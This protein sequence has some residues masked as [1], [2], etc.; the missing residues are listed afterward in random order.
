MPPSSLRSVYH[1]R[2]LETFRLKQLARCPPDIMLSHDWPRG[3]HK[4]GDVDQLLRC[5]YCD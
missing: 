4:Y 1:I 2:N 5:D 3:V